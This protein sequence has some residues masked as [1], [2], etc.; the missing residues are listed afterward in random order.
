MIRN[1]LLDLDNTILDFDRAERGALEKAFVDMGIAPT[2][3]LLD[4]YH[5]HNKRHWQMLER[6][7]ITRSQVLTG[8]F[9]DLFAEQGIACDPDAIQPVYERYLGIGHYFMEG[10]QALLD[11]LYGRYRLYIASNG[12]ANVQKT[13][14]ASAALARYMDQI[15]ISELIG[16]DKPSREFFDHCFAHIPDFKRVETVI[17]GDSL[18]SDILG[19]INAGI[20]TIWYNPRHQINSCSFEPDAETDA[21]SEIAPMLAAW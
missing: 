8:R 16:F 6:G 3:A 14:I 12:N 10:A 17:I 19:G 4:R 7:E 9:A 5:D 15:F 13:R 2:P 21:L 20:R 18:T 1:V 11:T